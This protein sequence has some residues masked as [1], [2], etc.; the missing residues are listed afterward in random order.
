MLGALVHKSDVAIHQRQGDAGS[1]RSSASFSSPTD[2]HGCSSDVRQHDSGCVHQEAGGDS[3]PDLERSHFLFAPPVRPGADCSTTCFHPLTEERVGRCSVQERQ[4][5]GDGVVTTPSSG[6]ATVRSLGQAGGRYVRDPGQSP[7][8]TVRVSVP[9]PE[10]HGDRRTVDQLGA[11]AFCVRLSTTKTAAS[12]SDQAQRGSGGESHSGSTLETSSILVSRAVGSGEERGSTR[13]RQESAV[14]DCPRN[15]GQV[16]LRRRVS[17]PSRVATL[18]Q[19]YMSRGYSEPTATKMATPQ[20]KST[21]TLYQARWNIFR[22]WC[23]ARALPTWDVQADSFAEFL[24]SRFD[25]GLSV[26]AVKGYRSAVSPILLAY[27]SYDP[28]QD[29]FLSLLVRHM[30]VQ[31][32]RLRHFLPKWNLAV[33]LQTFL[34]PPFVSVSEDGQVSPSDVSISLEHRTLKTVFLVALASGRHRAWIHALD[35]NELVFDKG[36]RPNQKQARL[37]PLRHF[38]DKNQGAKDLTEPLWIPGMKYLVPNDV[39]RF[40]CPVRQLALYK[41]DTARVRNGRSRLF[42]HWNQSILDIKTSHISRWIIDMIKL[43]YQLTPDE[44]LQSQPT[45]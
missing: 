14:T 10:V 34:R 3:F 41:H 7:T 45:R 4:A 31:R 20:R 5:S 37:F 17:Q 25:S 39:E 1:Y 8:A 29:P 32:P 19:L 38:R 11:L 33:V 40:L 43:A 23:A 18:T 30:Q 24:S 9:G 2:R 16:P 35:Y 15:R 26:T 28:S 13:S 42:L 36:D 21:Q 12:H 44:D 6:E 27:G 22:R